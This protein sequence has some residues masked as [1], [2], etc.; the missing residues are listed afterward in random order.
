VDTG[1]R[2]SSTSVI[3]V[4]DFG[5]ERPKMRATEDASC[6]KLK[7]GVMGVEINVIDDSDIVGWA[8]SATRTN[9]VYMTSVSTMVDNVIECLQD[10]RP[11]SPVLF[12]GALYPGLRSRGD[13]GTG[14]AHVAAERLGSRKRKPD[15]VRR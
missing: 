11:L 1:E 10:M 9:E 2:R 14:A 15:P 7:E 13:A 5:A 8:A 4:T 6:R 12:A 3:D